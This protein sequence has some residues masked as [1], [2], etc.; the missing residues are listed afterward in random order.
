MA[1]AEVRLLDLGFSVQLSN[2]S[3]LLQSIHQ[4]VTT[5]FTPLSEQRC[6]SGLKHQN[7]SKRPIVKQRKN[8][9]QRLTGKYP[10]KERLNCRFGSPSFDI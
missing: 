3:I 6:S 4:A 8:S 7:V 9:T 10:Q 2:G 5:S 1:V